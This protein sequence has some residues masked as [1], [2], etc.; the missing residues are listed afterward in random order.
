MACVNQTQ[1]HSV[2]QTLS[3]MAWHGRGTAWESHDMCE[4]AFHRL[5]LKMFT[6]LIINWC[7]QQ[8]SLLTC[9]F[10]VKISVQ[11]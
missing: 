11:A 2:N 3:S 4:L 7:C 5:S 9:A 6:A 10:L 1:L 8:F